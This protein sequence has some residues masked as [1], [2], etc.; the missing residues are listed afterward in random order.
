MRTWGAMG[1]ERLTTIALPHYE[2]GRK[3]V[4]VLL[5]EIGRDHPQ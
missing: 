2:L 4:E 1:T 5:A 3:A